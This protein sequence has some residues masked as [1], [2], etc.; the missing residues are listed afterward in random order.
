MLRAVFSPFIH[1]AVTATAA[2]AAV[3][4]RRIVDPSLTDDQEWSAKSDS[5]SEAQPP[6]G[7]IASTTVELT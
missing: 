1:E 3:S 2:I 6:S 7:P 4:A 5:S